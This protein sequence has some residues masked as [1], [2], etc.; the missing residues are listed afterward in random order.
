MHEVASVV[1]RK[2][3]GWGSL[4]WTSNSGVTRPQK[5][6]RTHGTQDITLRAS[7]ISTASR[8]SDTLEMDVPH[9]MVLMM[10]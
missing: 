1:E 9:Y 7:G 4:S 3:R 6:N 10:R 5:V 2:F 8:T